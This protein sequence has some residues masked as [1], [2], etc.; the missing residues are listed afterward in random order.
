M[1]LVKRKLDMDK[2]GVL[3]MEIGKSFLIS[4]FVIA[5]IGFAALIAINQLNLAH[6]DAGTGSEA[7]NR[8]TNVLNNI[9]AGT[10]DFFSNAGTW[11]SLLAVVILI[12]IIAVVIAVVNKFGGGR[13]GL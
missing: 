5:V 9:S 2:K 13:G 6:P 8:S 3:G 7:A 4:I 12:L 11:F 10:E 1:Q